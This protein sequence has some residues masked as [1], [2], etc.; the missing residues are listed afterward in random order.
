MVELVVKFKIGKLS[1]LDNS[2]IAFL[3]VRS[4][5]LKCID[6]SE[7]RGAISNPKL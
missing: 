1:E 7:R 2:Y 3:N 5:G 6:I 4:Q